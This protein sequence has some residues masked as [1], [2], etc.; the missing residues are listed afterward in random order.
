MEDSVTVQT[1][2]TCYMLRTR[3]ILLLLGLLSQWGFHY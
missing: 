2:S 1:L 3:V